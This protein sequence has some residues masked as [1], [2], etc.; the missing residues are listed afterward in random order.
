MTDKKKPTILVVDDEDNIRHL[1]RLAFENDYRVVEAS[2]GQEAL[3]LARASAPDLIL[4]DIMMP[5]LDGYGLFRRLRSAP[6]TASIP[7]VFLTAKKDVDDRVSGLEMGADDYITKPFSIKE[8]KAKVKSIS[9]KIKDLRDRGS[10]EG[11]LSEVDLVDV[12]QLIEMSR[13]TGTLLLVEGG[14]ETGRI[15]FRDGQPVQ[16]AAGKWQGVDAFF[17]LLTLEEGAFRLEPMVPDTADNL[18][19]RGGM[20]M[21]MEGVKCLDDMRSASGRLPSADTM[22]LPAA[23]GEK[24]TPSL[25][26][27]VGEAFAGGATLEQAQSRV[28]LPPYRFIPMVAEAWQSGALTVLPAGSDKMRIVKKFREYLVKL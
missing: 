27:E 18:E 2:D 8:L 14:D 24:T 9:R 7:F 5:R 3:E 16:A 25:A 23:G 1:L 13:K 19:V 22:L 17:T 11:L 10:L 15:V 6:E 20:E 12:I 4:S 28:A 21:L 26:P